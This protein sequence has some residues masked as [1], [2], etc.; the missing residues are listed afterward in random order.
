MSRRSLMRGAR[1]QPPEAGTIER[2]LLF[3]SSRELFWNPDMFP[4]LDSPHLFGDDQP[5]QLEIGCGT[6]EFL[7][8]LALEHPRTNFVGVDVA[9]K[10]LFK[11]I[12]TAQA[13]GL[14][15]IRFIRGDFKRMYP[16]LVADALQAVYLHFPD[17]HMRPRFRK[18]RMISPAFLDAI[19]RA[20]APGGQLSFMTDHYEFFLEMLALL[21]QDIRFA[22]THAE[23]YLIGFDAPAKSQFQRIWEQH[24]L[25]TLRV[26]LQKLDRLP[27][28]DARRS[29]VSGFSTSHVEKPDQAQ[30]LIA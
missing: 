3:F 22:K 20:L 2:Y 12:R 28:H 27:Q 14:P 13:H 26:E 6:A 25:P 4:P 24:G 29:G 1:F 21:E 18:H 19:D 10:P 9:P 16:L 15:N 7:C 17:P 23:R 11:A 30:S 5:L 8:A